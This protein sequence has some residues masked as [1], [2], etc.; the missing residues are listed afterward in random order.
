MFDLYHQGLIV[1][2]I[3]RYNFVDLNQDFE[4][5]VHNFKLIYNWTVY[6]RNNRIRKIVKYDKDFWIFFY[7]NNDGFS[8]KLLIDQAV[9]YINSNVKSLNYCEFYNCL[10]YNNKLIQIRNEN[11][12]INIKYIEDSTLNDAC[13]KLYKVINSEN[14]K[15]II[16]KS[17]YYK[18]MNKYGLKEIFKYSNSHLIDFEYYV[19]NKSKKL[20]VRHDLY[21][22]SNNNINVNHILNFS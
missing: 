11:L 8:N 1:Y 21:T 3:T 5:G 13:S 10:Y 14:S 17:T 2:S 19:Y 18:S 6:V 16:L 7:T 9:I 4:D 12:E 15:R 22:Y 20:L